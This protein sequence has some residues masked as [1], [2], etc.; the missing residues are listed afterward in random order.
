M[1][2]DNIQR[3]IGDVPS[4][5]RFR[6][7]SFTCTVF[8]GCNDIGCEEDLVFSCLGGDADDSGEEVL[9]SC[10]KVVSNHNCFRW[11]MHK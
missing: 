8:A 6:S 4:F 10:K 1:V 9:K 2:E 5:G 11:M 7:I 3:T